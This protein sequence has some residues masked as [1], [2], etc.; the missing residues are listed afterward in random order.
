MK[1]YRECTRKPYNS[2]TI[3][4]TLPAGDPL[5]FRKKLF[6][7]YIQ[8]LTVT[9]QIK[10]LN[11]K[12]L[13]LEAQ[14]DLDRQAAKM[15]VL[16]SNN[17]NKYKYLIGEDLGLKLSTVE[18]AKFEYSPLG[19][20][21][22]KGLSEDDKKEGLFKRIKNIENK[23]LTQLQAIKDQGEKQLKELKNIDKNKTLKAIDEISKR[24]AESNRTL[25]D[26]K[27]IDTKLDTAEL[28]CT[29]TDGTKY[30]FNTFALS[31]KFVEKIFNYEI[32]LDEAKD[33]QD[34]LEKLIIRLER[35]KPKINKKKNRREKKILRICSKIVSC[36]KR[37]YCFFWKRNFST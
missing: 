15:S 26:I 17:L 10:I 20:I 29:K 23:N 12:I 11:K 8:K 7:S 1:I 30:N 25:L 34:K 9:D 5:R 37:Y 3:D 33:D 21:F 24:N 4:T 35:Y 36:E 28:V 27:K 2:L 31:L 13:Q 18:Q 32:T 19:K 14:Y 22:N 6:D 16:S